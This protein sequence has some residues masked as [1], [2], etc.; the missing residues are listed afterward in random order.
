M[1]CSYELINAKFTLSRKSL[2]VRR[3]L[4]LISNKLKF[5]KTFLTKAAKQ[6]IIQLLRE[7]HRKFN[8]SV[9]KFTNSYKSKSL[10]CSGTVFE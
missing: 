6:T 4:F 10:S 2:I 3:Q 8:N 9:T 5:L 7:K 1:F